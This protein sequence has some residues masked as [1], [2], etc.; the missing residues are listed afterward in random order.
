MNMNFMIIGQFSILCC[1]TY[2]IHN[3]DDVVDVD[4]IG[5]AVPVIGP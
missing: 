5:V 4:V 1:Y 2:G 3:N